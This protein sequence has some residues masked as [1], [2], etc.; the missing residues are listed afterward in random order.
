MEMTKTFYELE[1]DI[2]YG[3][4]TPQERIEQLET[5]IEAGLI[6]VDIAQ[7]EI[8]L[9]RQILARRKRYKNS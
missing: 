3:M 5:L 7:D 8:E 4:L 6:D 9:N 2:Y 1:A